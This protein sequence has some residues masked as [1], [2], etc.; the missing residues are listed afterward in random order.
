MAREARRFAAALAEGTSARVEEWD[1]RLTTARAER[2]IRDADVPRRRRRERG[3]AD[4]I[5]ASLVLQ[6]YM[7]WRE[8]HGEPEPGEVGGQEQPDRPEDGPR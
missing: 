6:A 1:E 8:R 4:R 7:N 3:A 5:A 2:A